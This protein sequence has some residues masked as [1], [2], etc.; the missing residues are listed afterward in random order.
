MPSTA[1]TSGVIAMV[2]AVR[3][4]TPPPFEISFLS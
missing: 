3:G 4:W 1:R 2:F